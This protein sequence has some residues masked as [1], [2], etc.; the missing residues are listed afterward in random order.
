MNSF[1]LSC[2]STADLSQQHFDAR[3]IHYICFH[4]SLND[5]Q[6][7]D[8]LG[9]SISFPDFYE[10]MRN[11]AETKTSQVNEGE[12]EDYFTPFLEAGK[13]I[14]HVCL[15]SGISGVYNSAMLAK[16]TLEEKYPERKIFILDSLNASSGYGLLMDALADKRDEGF[17]AQETYA[18][19][20]AHRLNFH[21]WFFSTDLTFYV[22]GGRISRT[23]GLVGSVLHICPLL[24]MDQ[25]GKLIP[26][27]KIR[28]KT[29]VISRIVEK[30]LLHAKDGEN[31][32]GK[33]F[34]SHSDCLEDAQAVAALIEEKFKKLNGKVLINSVGT[35][36]GSHTGP[37]TVALFFE[38]DTRQE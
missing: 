2:C 8:D 10:A 9:K 34:I 17:S 33:C 4:F 26:K 19:G 36:I 30:M 27:E 31:Y 18:W 25:A 28:T 32:S 29:K 22:K 23:S 21:A 35:T 14:V 1:V 7:A 3:D 5:R 37:G 16:R 12:F 20:M 6:Y 38:G 11:G 15:S 24:H 13:D